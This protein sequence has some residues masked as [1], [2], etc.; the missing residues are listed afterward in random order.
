M[1]DEGLAI[2]CTEDQMNKDRRQRL[3][4]VWVPHFRLISRFQ[5]L[6]TWRGYTLSWGA[7]AGFFITRPWRLSLK[8]FVILV[9]LVAEGFQSIA[10]LQRYTELVRSFYLGRCPRLLHCAPSAL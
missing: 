2:F 3:G 7:A 1:S 5:R 8:M 10:R 6:K 9:R 4:H